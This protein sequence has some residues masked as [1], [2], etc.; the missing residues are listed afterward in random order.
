MEENPL[1]T[2]ASLIVKAR[3]AGDAMLQKLVET[4][5]ARKSA[6]KALTE[7]K[8]TLKRAKQPPSKTLPRLLP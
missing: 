1:P 7:A 5:H 4:R 8:N 3:A 6:M 2:T